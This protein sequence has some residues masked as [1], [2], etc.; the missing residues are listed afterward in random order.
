MSTEKVDLI[1]LPKPRKEGT[2]SV[3]AALATRRSVRA[4]TRDE[5]TQDQ[6]GQ[7]LWAAQGISGGTPSKRTAPSAGG[8]HPLLFYVCCA[9]GI[10]L[11]SPER[12]TLKH[13]W[14][15]DI[16]GGLSIAAWKQSFLDTAPCVFIAVAIYRRM[17]ERYGER[18]RMRYVPMDL[19]HATQNLLLQAVAL[20][21]GSV[22]VGAF[23]DAQISEVAHLSANEEPLY[24]IPVGYPA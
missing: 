23:D 9:D 1:Q 18:G 24:L 17:T 14:D 3:E 11:Y 4:Y 2:L 21:L 15:E 5:L 22:V 10:W 8:L 13:H 20:G 6:I 19:G 16:R 12:H 7:L